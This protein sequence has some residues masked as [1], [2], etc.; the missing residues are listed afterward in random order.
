[1]QL[2][3]AK[4]LIV[5]ADF[6]PT[7][8]VLDDWMT[9]LSAP[10][11]SEWVRR[12]VL[13]LA[14]NLNGTGVYLKVNS[15]LRLCGYGLINEIKSCGLGVFADLKL[16]DIGN[17][18][19]TDGAILQEFKPELL[20][21]MCSAGEGA[22]IALKKALPD[23]EVLGVT[24]L[25]SLSAEDIEAVHGELTRNAVVGNLAEIALSA[26][27]DGVVASPMEAK[28]LRKSLGEKMTINTPAIR[29][30]WAIVPG[31]DNAGNSTA[32]KIAIE[33]GA[34]RIVVGRPILQAPSPYD[35][36]MRTIEEIEAALQQQS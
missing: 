8:S 24:A 31:D 19:G 12:Q 32:P 33:L 10:K 27:L 28:M 14:E 13:T 9:K 16:C 34:T 5:A 1:M 23:T 6:K 17:T 15:A 20:T 4:R 36:V 29:P 30:A 7:H 22:L 3:S 2:T 26:G 25:T 11:P 18:L 35:A 21:V